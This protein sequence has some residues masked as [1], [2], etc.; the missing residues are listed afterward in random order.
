[1]TGYSWSKKYWKKMISG[2]LILS[3]GFLIL[4]HLFNF[5][6]FD[7]EILGH[8]YTG[9]FLIGIAFLLS[10]TGLFLIGIAFLLSMKWKQLPAFIAAIKDR[11]LKKIFDEG[12]R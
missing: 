9:L 6:G 10:N 5:G 12:E 1:M 3:G 8:E 11:N 7:L 4:E 2:M